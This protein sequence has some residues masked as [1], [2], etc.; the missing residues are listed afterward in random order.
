[1]FFFIFQLLN[2]MTAARHMDIFK[3]IKHVIKLA[4][5]Y[6]PLQS[7]YSI[8]INHLDIVPFDSN[9]IRLFIKELF[10][11]KIIKVDLYKVIRSFSLILLDY[12]LKL[13]F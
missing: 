6:H 8:N 1:M 12:S 3:S 7:N 13:Y 11:T 2:F 4:N 9:K 10:L 5:L